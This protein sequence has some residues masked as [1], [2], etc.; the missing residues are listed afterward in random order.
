MNLLDNPNG[1]YRFLTGIAPYS[2]GVV[3]MPGYEIVRVTLQRSLPYR[4]GFDLI[5]QYLAALERPR[6]ALCAVELRLPRPLSFAGFARFNQDYQ[7]LLAAWNLWVEGRNPIARTNVAPLLAA[8]EE[9]ALYAFAYTVPADTLAR[10]TTFVVAGAGELADQADLSPSAVVRPGETAP[11]ALREKAQT[12]MAVMQTRLA[13][14]GADWD[15]VTAVEIYTDQPIHSFLDQVILEPMGPAAAHGVHW[16]LS[17][18][19][20]ADLVFE[21]DLR[22]VRSE[23]RLPG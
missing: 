10:P 19:P 4:T 20:I 17:R 3:A 9:P 5:A 22:G 6:A 7:K 11:E 15:A 12:V 1:N 13:G 23:L 14:L 18:P 16:Y 21:M 8:P 2:A